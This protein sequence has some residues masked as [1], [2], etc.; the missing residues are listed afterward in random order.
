MPHDTIGVEKVVAC[1][2]I[3]QLQLSTRYGIVGGM[4]LTEQLGVRSMLKQAKYAEKMQKKPEKG[5]ELMTYV[6]FGLT[7]GEQCE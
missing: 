2:F 7:A 3:I 4:M 6:W 5:P 1:L